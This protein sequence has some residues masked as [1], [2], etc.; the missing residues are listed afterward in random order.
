MARPSVQIEVVQA[1]VSFEREQGEGRQPMLAHIIARDVRQA[2]VEM[3]IGGLPG[4]RRQLGV[5]RV[6][7][8]APAP[9]AAEVD[10]VE[11]GDLAVRR[12]RRRRRA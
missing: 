11:M 10:P 7:E 4:K 5:E 3:G 2:G 12:G 6:G 8:A 9:G 1:I